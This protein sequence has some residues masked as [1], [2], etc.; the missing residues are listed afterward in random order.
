MDD[1]PAERHV[2]SPD[3][4]IAPLVS[5]GSGRVVEASE[6]LA[7]FIEGQRACR[8]ALLAEAAAAVAVSLLDVCGSRLGC[9]PVVD[10]SGLEDPALLAVVVEQVCARL[11]ECH[12]HRIVT[13]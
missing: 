7:R 8:G 11:D 1:E 3:T 10:M 6:Q 9:Q 12:G 4:L 13:A 5:T 2:A